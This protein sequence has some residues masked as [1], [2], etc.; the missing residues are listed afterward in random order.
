RGEVV[1]RFQSE[2]KSSEDKLSGS[3]GTP[4]D[5]E[6]ESQT[7]AGGANVVP[8]VDDK[9]D[10]RF[11]G[12]HDHGPLPELKSGG[13]HGELVHALLD[14]K[15]DSDVFLTG[16][17]AK[18]QQRGRL[19]QPHRKDNVSGA[20][21]TGYEGTEPASSHQANDQRPPA[22]PTNQLAKRPRS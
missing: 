7:H 9:F 17:I 4:D 13:I 22:S 11:T 14:A 18:E 10:H 20:S 8:Q 21:A 6:Q 15:A 2:P 1:H 16:L 19:Q 3:V 12:R 5:L